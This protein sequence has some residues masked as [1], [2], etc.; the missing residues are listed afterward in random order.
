MRGPRHKLSPNLDWCN[1]TEIGPDVT[2]W[3]ISVTSQHGRSLCDV[4][5]WPFSLWRHNMADLSVT[6][7]H[8]HSLCD[9]TTW[10]ISLWRHNMADLSVTSQH[11]RSLCEVTTW[12]ISSQ[13]SPPIVPSK[14]SQVSPRSNH[15]S[16][17]NFYILWNGQKTEH[18]TLRSALIIPSSNLTLLVKDRAL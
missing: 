13:F 4:T 3:W 7:Q 8:G 2:T 11:G 17:E 18:R 16:G 12:R 5:T 1:I 15:R 6:S 14:L 10:W 9:V